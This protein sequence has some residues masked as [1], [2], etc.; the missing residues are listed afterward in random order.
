MSADPVGDRVDPW[1]AIVKATTAAMCDHLPESK[2]VRPLRRIA[3]ASSRS[4]AS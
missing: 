2:W 1:I 3:S 4:T